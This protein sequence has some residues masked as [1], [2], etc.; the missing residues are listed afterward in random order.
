MTARRSGARVKD[1]AVRFVLR[2]LVGAYLRVRIDG[3]ESLPDS[4]YLVCFN[5]PSWSDPLILVGYWPDRRRRLLIFGPRE[6]DMMVGRRNAL[7]RWTDRGVPFQPAGADVVDVTRRAIAVLRG[8]GILTI[9]GE[10]RLSDRE[11]EVLPLQV[12]LGH[13]ALLA[14]VPIVP[15]A[16][17]GTRWLRFGKTIRL[18]IGSPVA[19]E[20]L[21]R[22]RAGAI[23]LTSRV[24][25]ALEALLAGPH[26][27]REPRGRFARWLSEAFN[28]RPWLTDPSY[29]PTVRQPRTTSGSGQASR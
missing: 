29:D 20:G 17:S 27:E 26:D 1:A 13:F 14:D 9:A 19:I 5:H 8:G 3:G 28:E 15:C 23:E 18:N 2:V 25:T 6:R 22:G 11:G 16:I 12:G 4:A 21:P 10:G 7:I 24:Q